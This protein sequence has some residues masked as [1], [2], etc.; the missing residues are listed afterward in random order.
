MPKFGKESLKMLD[1]V[2]PKLVK[3]CHLAIEIMDFKVVDGVRTLEEQQINKLRGVSWTLN[4]KHILQADGYSHAVD[5][6]PYVTGVDWHDI[7]MFCVLAGVMFACAK[8]VGIKLR[9]GGDWNQNMQTD[10]EKKDRR[11]FGHFEVI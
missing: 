10:D 2:H 7:E 4:S 8:H 1:G 3:V 9:W 6:G 11:D 5:L